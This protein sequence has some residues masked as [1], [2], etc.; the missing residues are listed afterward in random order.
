M[1]STVTVDAS[2]VTVDKYGNDVDQYGN[3]TNKWVKKRDGGARRHK[4]GDNQAHVGYSF[5]SWQRDTLGTE[6][7]LG[8]EWDGNGQYWRTWEFPNVWSQTFYGQVI[9]ALGGKACGTSVYVRNSDWVNPA[10]EPPEFR[11]V[12]F[13][14]AAMDWS[15]SNWWDRG[16]DQGY[17][18][19]HVAGY[20]EGL[21]AGIAQGKARKGAGKG[22][23]GKNTKGGK[24]GGKGSHGKNM[25][26]GKYGGK[27]CMGGKGV[28]ASSH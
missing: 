12:N 9:E 11:Q 23:T 7:M 16:Y 1:A 14:N 20:E 25:K 2:T 19:G 22:S 26:H 4:A 10:F 6:L 27:G 21:A 5:P 8:E 28:S 18:A 15:Q 17:N 24:C 13:D 3:K